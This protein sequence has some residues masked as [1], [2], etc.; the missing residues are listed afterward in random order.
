MSGDTNVKNRNICFSITRFT[1]KI[2]S[3]IHIWHIKAGK[4]YKLVSLRL[5]PE[6]V[7]APVS[8]RSSRRHRR[9]EGA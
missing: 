4:V 8:Y 2:I 5:Q 9:G 3:A 1:C 7:L 6:A